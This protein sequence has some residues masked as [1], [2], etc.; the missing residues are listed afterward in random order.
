LHERNL[1]RAAADERGPEIRGFLCFS[2]EVRV[3]AG[4]SGR[5]RTL[6][7]QERPRFRL[8]FQPRR[9]VSLR[10]YGPDRPSASRPTGSRRAWSS[11]IA[12]RVRPNPRDLGLFQP[13]RA[14]LLIPKRFL[15]VPRLLATYLAVSF[16][17]IRSQCGAPRGR[18]VSRIR[19]N[20]RPTALPDGH[21]IIPHRPVQPTWEKPGMAREG[22]WIPVGVWGPS[23]D[24][25]KDSA[26][27][28]AAASW[29]RT[30]PTVSRRLRAVGTRAEPEAG[31]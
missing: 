7:S 30:D 6:I 14:R 1:S 4:S 5:M 29:A 19:R 16:V 10:N 23:R 28:V 20:S 24:G 12:D 2:V 8:D 17:E 31:S 9:I 27:F 3:I 13:P 25:G 18:G 21:G 11:R 22:R 26:T 15:I